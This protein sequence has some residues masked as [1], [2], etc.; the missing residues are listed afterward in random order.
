MVQIHYF[1]LALAAL[2][3]GLMAAPEIDPAVTVTIYG[4]PGYDETVYTAN[5]CI[6]LGVNGAGGHTC[7]YDGEHHNPSNV[8]QIAC[9]GL[10]P[11]N[12]E[13]IEAFGCSRNSFNYHVCQCSVV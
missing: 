2:V 8:G 1:A 5:H 9:I 10:R 12:F 6:E 4:M 3:P 13:R 7:M 11:Q